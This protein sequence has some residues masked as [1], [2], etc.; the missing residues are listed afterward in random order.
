M[1]A[2]EEAQEGGSST[3]S[4]RQVADG[5][6]SVRS[7]RQVA[8]GTSRLQVPQRSQSLSP[9]PA[10][11]TVPE[12]EQQA[13]SSAL[14]RPAE[15][16]T[17]SPRAAW[18]PSPQE[19]NSASTTAQTAAGMSPGSSS[20]FFSPSK[21]QKRDKDLRPATI[22]VRDEIK[23]RIQTEEDERLEEEDWIECKTPIGQPYFWNARSGT[24]KWTKANSERLE[25]FK[26]MAHM[27]NTICWRILELLAQWFGALHLHHLS[28]EDLGMDDMAALVARQVTQ[29][30]EGG[31]SVRS[32]FHRM[33]ASPNVKGGKKKLARNSLSAKTV[34]AIDRYLRERG[35]ACEHASVIQ[36]L[37]G[38]SEAQLA[39]HFK[40]SRES[41]K[42]WI[43]I[44]KEVKRSLL[45]PVDEETPGDPG[46]DT[47]DEAVVTRQ[48]RP[49]FVLGQVL[50]CAGLWLI[51]NNGL[52]LSGLDA[53]APGQTDLR[54]MWDCLDSRPEIWRWLTYQFTHGNS[55]HISSNSLMM[56]IFGIQLEGVHG[57]RRLALMFNVGILGG[58]FCCFV[59]AVHSRVVGMSGG[60][61]ALIGM[62]VG[63]ALMNWTEESRAAEHFKKAGLSEHGAEMVQKAWKRMFFPPTLKLA[64]I[65]VW[66]AIDVALAMV[67]DS[68]NV[69]HAAHFGGAIAGFLI[70]VVVGRNVVVRGY[71]K[72]MTYVA[73][74]LGCILTLFSFIWFLTSPMRS[75]FED[76]DWCWTRQV[77]NRTLF[78][79]MDPH[80]VRCDAQPCV[81][82]WVATQKPTHV[83]PVSVSS[84]E[85]IGG[86]SS[87]KP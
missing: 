71:E 65:F 37:F 5:A 31:Q 50:L 14:R 21:A 83:A 77:I 67:S 82:R 68:S 57:A 39:Q 70:C 47:E 61:Y 24:S 27:T 85:Q 53:L 52:Q 79:D 3:R 78:S 45:P 4:S 56:L 51:P 44:D 10:W 76:T 32:Y 54:I 42:M 20:S 64:I 6:S 25:D 35:K 9:R 38:V 22:G 87:A 80:C 34:D 8:E 7:S 46:P 29:M 1:T 66:V 30:A 33:N 2:A 81:A 36:L 12:D 16:R 63:D 86:W 48:H 41:G 18:G 84:C 59:G 23:A 26:S 19:D 43:F 55:A 40:L 72:E 17:P 69:S 58:A 73:L 11:D 13:S 75:I 49:F 74:V 28:P 62:H 60:C 15:L